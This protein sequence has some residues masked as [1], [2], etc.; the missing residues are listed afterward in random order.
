[1]EYNTIEKR[2]RLSHQ[3]KKVKLIRD[4]MK[5]KQNRVRNW[6]ISLAASLLLMSGFIFYTV[7][8]TKEAVITGSVYSYQYRAEQISYNE[9]L[10]LAHKELD[11]GN[12]QHI[13]ELLSGIEESDHKDWLNL[14]ANIGVENYDGAKVIMQKIKK[15]KDHLYHNRISTTFKIDITLLALKKKINL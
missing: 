14:Q 15:D 7:Q 3:N 10:M 12:Y 5:R 8:V 11:K 6:N 13:L 9:A 2:I 1:M 4:K